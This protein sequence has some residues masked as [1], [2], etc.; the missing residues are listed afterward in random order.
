MR[1]ERQS[2][3]NPAAK[4]AFDCE[5][6][7]ARGLHEHRLCWT[8]DKAKPIE[9][10]GVG[11][12]LASK[13]DLQ[14]ILRHDEHAYDDSQKLTSRGRAICPVPLSI[15]DALSDLLQMEADL[16]GWHSGPLEGGVLDW[17]ADLVLALRHVRGVKGMLQ[18]KRIREEEQHGTLRPTG[19][20]HP[21]VRGD[22][23]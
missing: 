5:L 22:R 3:K 8:D 9:V 13:Q 19:Y 21:Q 14:E 11:P 1:E 16:D 12:V 23:P 7:R 15:D 18:M 10:C 6:C 4:I 2:K 20:G 17:P